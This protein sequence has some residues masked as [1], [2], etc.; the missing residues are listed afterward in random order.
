MILNNLASRLLRR[1]GGLRRNDKIV[2]HC[3]KA[4][5]GLPPIRKAYD[6]RSFSIFAQ[7]STSEIVRLKTGVPGAVSLS[8]QK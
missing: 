3:D 1:P 7:V 2:C 8:A 6:P 4:L 5:V